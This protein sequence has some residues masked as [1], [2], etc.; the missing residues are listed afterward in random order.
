[1]ST[2]TNIKDQL[3]RDEGLRLEPYQDTRGIWTVGYGHNLQAHEQLYG[4]HSITLEQAEA[5]LDQDIKRAEDGLDQY[6]SDWRT[7]D[8]V[9][10][11]SLL[12]LTF[13]LGIEGL[14]KFK[15]FLFL[16]V[17]GSYLFA[18]QDLLK[19]L[20]AKQV[21]KRAA[22]VAEQIKTGNWV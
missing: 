11:G 21:P 5:L 1:M 17:R 14:L 20:Y 2:P 10:Q 4:K 7:H 9:R 13:Q 15:K 16:F 6:I 3:K 12:N 18:S 19:T 22:R 8:T